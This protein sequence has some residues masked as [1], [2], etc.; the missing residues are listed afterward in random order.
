[1]L[2]SFFSLCVL[3]SLLDCR[4]VR[5]ALTTPITYQTEADKKDIFLP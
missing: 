3:H 1:M 2:K 5:N 4:V